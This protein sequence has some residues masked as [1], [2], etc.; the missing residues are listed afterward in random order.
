MPQRGCSLSGVPSSQ[1]PGKGADMAARRIDV[2]P[3]LALIGALM[4]L[5]SLFLDWF[6]AGATAWEVFEVLD[7]VLAACAIVAILA[8]LAVAGAETVIDPRALG[9]AAAIAVVVVIA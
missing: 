8:A 5:V 9:W 3:V 4:L 6:E 7:L 1:G 2:G